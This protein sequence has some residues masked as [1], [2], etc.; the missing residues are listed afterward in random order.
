MSLQTQSSYALNSL[1]A[2]CG[3]AKRRKNPCVPS[4]QKKV[5]T[6]PTEAELAAAKAVEDKKAADAAAQAEAEAKAKEDAEKKGKVGDIFKGKDNKGKV[7]PEATFLEEKKARKEAERKLK[8]LEDAGA[9]K[10]EIKASLKEIAEKYD[11]DP[12]LMQSIVSAVKSEADADIDEKISS[13]IKPIE[14]K[15]KQEKIDKIFNEHYDKTLAEMPEYKNVANKTVIKSLTLDPA[16]ANKTFSQILEEAYGH[17][18]KTTKKPIE[19]VRPKDGGAAETAIDYARAKS[20]PEYFKEIM[21][22]PQ[23][24]AEYNKN[25]HKR[26]KL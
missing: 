7:V 6:M 10:K 26:L 21:A 1:P 20:D 22:D 9:S 14:E 18:V 15:D 4:Q 25:L 3:R 23:Q 19:G 2:R 12:D 13:R 16:N 5:T 11:V 24:K 8:E 17:L